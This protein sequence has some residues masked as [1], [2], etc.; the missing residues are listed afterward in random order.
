MSELERQAAGL[1]VE[2]MN[3]EGA[4]SCGSP[5][6][7]P[8]RDWSQGQWE[9]GVRTRLVRQRGPTDC[10]VAC[11]AMAAGI[12]YERA[13]QVFRE[14]GLDS[15]NSRHG[16]PL[17]SNFRNLETALRLHCS[18]PARRRRWAG[19]RELELSLESGQLGILKVWPAASGRA[20]PKHSHW[21]V[22]EAHA[23]AGI[24][25]RDPW[26]CL[27]G[28]RSPIFNVLHQ[29]LDCYEPEGCWIQVT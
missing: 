24:I 21:V 19:W 28:L 12:S 8:D 10:G 4:E 1:S 16:K 20:R 26:S 22:A 7:H 5:R 11:L 3:S 27:V 29:S 25:I 9:A 6:E 18:C 14:L 17:L 23:V 15:D 13:L 2:Q